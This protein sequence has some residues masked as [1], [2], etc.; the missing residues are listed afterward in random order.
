[1]LLSVTTREGMLKPEGCIID[2]DSTQSVRK[3]GSFLLLLLFFSEIK[4]MFELI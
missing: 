2:L 4:G 1:M 3:M